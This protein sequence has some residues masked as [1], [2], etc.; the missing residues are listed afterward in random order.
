LAE[1]NGIPNDPARVAEL[2]EKLKY[3][4]ETDPYEGFDYQAYPYVPEINWGG[5]HSHLA[6][7]VCDIRPLLIIEVGSWTGESAR[8]MAHE[9]QGLGLTDSRIV[10]VDTWLGNV[11][12]WTIHSGGHYPGLKM[13]NGHPTIYQQFLANTCYENM[14]QYIVPFPQTSEIAAL[15][16]RHFGFKADLIYIDGRHEFD[17]VYRDVT[18]YYKLLTEKGCLFGD[19]YFVGPVKAAVDQFAQEADLNV[20]VV[21][22]RYWHYECRYA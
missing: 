22:N 6:E 10:C 13:K 19:D 11:D 12:C 21:E 17:F 7:M 14:Q 16:F 2:D 4:Q 3:I 5:S 8:N 9:L 15:F 18:D 20:V 1:V